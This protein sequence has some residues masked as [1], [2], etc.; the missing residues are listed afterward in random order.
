MS[1]ISFHQLPQLQ[2]N[3]RYRRSPEAAAKLEKGEGWISRAIE[4]V[5]VPV[6]SCL[7]ARDLFA[8]VLVY[9]LNTE[10][11]ILIASEEINRNYCIFK[12]PNSS[13]S[14]VEKR[15][16]GQELGQQRGL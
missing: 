8:S 13:C 12:V 9:L 14:A 4:G 5:R 1:I 16:C 7:E 6:S 3:L 2:Q 10:L 15:H 11:V